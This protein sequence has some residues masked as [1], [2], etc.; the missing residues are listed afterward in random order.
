[1]RFFAD[2]TLLVIDELGYLPLPAEAASALVQVINQRYLKTSIVIS[3]NRP[4]GAWG[5]ILCDT[6]VAAAMPDLLLHR[7][8]FVTHNGASC[9]RRPIS[10]PISTIA[11]PAMI[12]PIPIHTCRARTAPS[13]PAA[14]PRI[15][16]DL[17]QC[18]T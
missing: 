5:K 12:S 10:V 2:T 11:A 1:M 13:G 7:S 4:V 18:D 17:R 16:R 8:V 9:P 3:T 15:A 6:T 14:D